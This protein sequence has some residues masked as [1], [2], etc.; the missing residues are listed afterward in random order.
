MKINIIELNKEII[1]KNKWLICATLMFFVIS[2]IWLLSLH[3]SFKTTGY[4]LGQ[5][6]QM[7]W[8]TVNGEGILQTNLRVRPGN[9]DGFY[10][11]EHFSPILFLFTPVFYISPE[12]ETLLILKTFFISLS[13]PILWK[14]TRSQLSK[15]ISLIIIISYVLNPFLLEALSF[16]FQE[17]FILPFIIFSGFYFYFNKKYKPFIFF[18]ILGLTV[19]EYS[20]ALAALAL[21]GLAITE[22]NSLRYNNIEDKIKDR[23]FLIPLSLAVISLVYFFI[24]ISIME[25]H[26]DAGIIVGEGRVSAIGYVFSLISDPSQTFDTILRHINDKFLYLNLFLM[27]TFYIALLSPISSLPLL[28]Y[29]SF[30]WLSD[31]SS[32]YEFGHHHSFYLIPYIYIGYVVSIKNFEFHKISI[33]NRSAQSIFNLAVIISILLFM[34][35]TSFSIDKGI[36]PDFGEHTNTLHNILE[37]IPHNASILTQNNIHPHVSARSK[38]YVR[39]DATRYDQLIKI[40]RTIDFEY[41]ILD[42]KS[43]WS[44]NL[45]PIL[46]IIEKSKSDNYGV[47]LYTDGI[48]VLKRDYRGPVN[49]IIERS[50][51]RAVAE[52]SVFKASYTKKDLILQEGFE[53][54]DF[55]VHPSGYHGKTF[56]F[57]PYKS[58]RSGV[59]IVTFEIKRNGKK[60]IDDDVHLITLDV[61]KNRAKSVK[62]ILASKDVIYSEVGNEWTNISLTF[63]INSLTTDIEF[64]GTN[65]SPTENIYLKRIAIKE[66]I[67]PP[68]G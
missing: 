2:S 39:L 28:L 33:S 7:F 23:K 55:L 52:E 34:N 27:P 13:I 21:S 57:G 32:F 48:Y 15:R 26:A 67:Y 19:N 4:D 51:L 6:T 10:I 47:W 62:D 46:E 3:Y 36:F 29:T 8:K 11:W 16:D 14:I 58:L 65:P 9:P 59:Y 44:E 25:S 63:E 38:S 20:A 60:N 35:Q 37:Y 49:R 1:N 61:V 45:K 40:K 18:T 43:G 68:I 54:G 17:Q 64:R 24:A 30:G 42:K 53:E 56:W 50:T 66:L 22:Y 41:I 5:Y 12:P 31:Y